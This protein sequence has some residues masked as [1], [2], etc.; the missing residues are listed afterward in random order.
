[1]QYCGYGGLAFI[2]DSCFWVFE[3]VGS[4]HIIKD[5]LNILKNS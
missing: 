2:G 4:M 5:K 1:M 3:R